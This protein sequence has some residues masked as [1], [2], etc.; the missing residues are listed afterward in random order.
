MLYQLHP[1]LIASTLSARPQKVAE[2]ILREGRL[3]RHLL[4]LRGSGDSGGRLHPL[5]VADYTISYSML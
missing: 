1:H 3:L 2:L 5:M 4:V